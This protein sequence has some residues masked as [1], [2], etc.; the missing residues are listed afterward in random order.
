VIALAIPKIKSPANILF[1]ANDERPIQPL[2]VSPPQILKAARRQFGVSDRTLDRAMAQI[3]LQRPG[4]ST[5]VRQRVARGVSEHVRMHL[6]RHFGLDPDALDH[7]LQAGHG[8]VALPA[9]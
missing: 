6:K 7:L 9:R 3:R 4:V 8:E 1:C 2:E 5:L